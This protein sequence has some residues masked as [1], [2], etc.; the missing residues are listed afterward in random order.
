MAEFKRKKFLGREIDTPV[1]KTDFYKSIKP[2]NT[3][4]LEI[5]WI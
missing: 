3:A 4:F 1:N 2:A 5:T